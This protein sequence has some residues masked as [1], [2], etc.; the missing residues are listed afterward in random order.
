M[1]LTEQE[2]RSTPQALDKTCRYL[3]QEAACIHPLM[4]RAGSRK[5]TFL[6]CGS[7]YM[8]AKSAAAVFGACPNTSAC[9]IPAGDYLLCPSFWQETVRDSLVVPISRSG[10]TSELV[11]AVQHIRQTLGCPVLSLCTMADNDV[12]AL[13]DRELLLD[14]C[15]DESVCQTRTVTNLYTALLLLAAEYAGNAALRSAVETICAADGN[16]QQQHWASLAEVAKKPW[17]SAVVLADG[18]LCGIGEE[19]ALA[20]TEISMLCGRYFH[21]LDY[22]HGPMVLAN[23]RLLTVAVLRPGQESLQRAMAEDIQRRGGSVVFLSE[24]AVGPC[25]LHIP[26]PKGLDFAAWGISLI[27]AV[28]ILAFEKALLLGGNPDQPKGLDAYITL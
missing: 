12:T 10:K 8:L 23:D 14:W 26:I 2:I 21:L 28:Q 9:A 20:F 6:G 19:G 4:E 5:L 15:C 7:S 18:P 25:D 1:F 11:R 17:D 13:C 3:A 27:T 22:R 16:Y 24:D